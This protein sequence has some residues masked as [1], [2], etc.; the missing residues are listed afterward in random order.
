MQTARVE[1]KKMTTGNPNITRRALERLLHSAAFV[2]DA[3]QLAGISDEALEQTLNVIQNAS[4]FVG[5]RRLHDL[6][7]GVIGDR[8]QS[9][10]LVNFIVNFGEMR[11]DAE[12]SADAF[13]ESIIAGLSPDLDDTV[14]KALESRLGRILTPIQGLE[15]QAKAERVVRKTGAHLDEFAFVSDLRPVFDVNGES[16]D[17]LIPLTTLKLVVHRP[18]ELS[19]TMVEAYLTEDEL[20]EFSRGVER[21]KRKLQTLKQLVKMQ[22]G[23]ELPESMITLSEQLPS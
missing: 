3:K 21:A 16:V 18:G 12:I 10:S 17:G 13:A 6:I 22:T 11:R 7:I 4:G 20:D 2:E 14:R 23:I 19:P 9:T 5:A 15:R 1:H 8:P